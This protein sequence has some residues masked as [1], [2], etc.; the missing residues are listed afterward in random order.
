MPDVT[1]D[2][3][4][5]ALVLRA[6]LPLAIADDLAAFPDDPAFIAEQ[7]RTY[8]LADPVSQAEMRMF[9]E[10]GGV[11]MVADAVERLAT[12]RDEEQ[13]K[14]EEVAELEAALVLEPAR[15]DPSLCPIC[16]AVHGSVC[17]DPR[18]AEVAS[19]R[20]NLAR[21]HDALDAAREVIAHEREKGGWRE[22]ARRLKVACWDA[23]RAAEL[24]AEALEAVRRTGSLAEVHA[25]VDEVLTET[26]WGAAFGRLDSKEANRA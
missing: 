5:L 15:P 11:A 9:H 26:K 12:P 4:P 23:L 16:D 25:I 1:D 21:S 22:A 7:T 19:L 18:D 2:P 24:L 10:D 3:D 20:A 8:L 17:Q 13:I 14:T 6:L